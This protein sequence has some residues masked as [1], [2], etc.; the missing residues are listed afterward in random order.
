LRGLH[1]TE[2]EAGQVAAAGRHQAVEAV[3]QAEGHHQAV[4]A[5]EQAVEVHPF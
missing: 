1:Q 5:V 4:E 2:Q 3:G